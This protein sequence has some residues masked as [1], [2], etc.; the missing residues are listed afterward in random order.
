MEVSKR[1]Q[2]VS[3]SQTL[4]MTKKARELAAT[5]AKVINLSIG[6]PDFDTP[7][8]IRTAAKVAIDDGW[9]HYTPVPGYPDLRQ[10]ISDKFKSQNGLN[11]ATNQI[12]VSGG[13][14]HS[15]TNVIFSLINEGDE[16]II[17]APYWV[18]YPEMVKLA[19]GVPVIL[20][21]DITSD[22]HFSINDLK[23]ALSPKTKLFLFSS[24]CNPSGTVFSKEFLTEIANVIAGHDD[25]M[26]I[27]D[28][29]Y[30]H[31]QYGDSHTSIGSLGIIDE[32]V[33]TVNGLS[34]GFA[35]TGW[36][37]GY[38]GAPAWVAKAVEKLQGQFTSGTNSVAQ[39]AA[40]SALTGSLDDTKHMC[41]IFEKR[42]KIIYDGLAAIDGI[43]PN[44]PKGA[45][46]VF[47]DVSAF[48]GKSH[49]NTVIKDASDLCLYLL[50]DAHVS[51]VT[52][53]A[54]GNPECIRISYAASETDLNEALS[55]IKNSLEK[56][57]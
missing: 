53:G 42:R 31:I 17:P 34:K 38:L 2:A 54:F 50:Q 49:D 20:K 29:I 33:I 43:N 24:P 40:I 5:G 21:S 11:Y 41:Q 10:A 23:S 51:M 57:A 44:F 56:L 18:S 46:Y 12:V 48:F 6:E 1:L 3:E 25:M 19:G 26:V 4:V 8:F 28:E 9:T 39:R 36:R 52:G 45:F 14:K 16:V 22:Y 15:I 37:I 55:R 32:R 27:S 7:E 30:E 47:P 13:A 35:M